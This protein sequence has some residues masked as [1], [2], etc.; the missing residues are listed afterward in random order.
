[1][2]HRIFER[3]SPNRTL[4]LPVAE[5]SFIQLPMTYEWDDA[6]WQ[7]EFG[8]LQEIGMSYLVVMGTSRTDGNKTQTTYPTSL[9]NCSMI[10]PVDVIDILLRNAS[11][12]GFKVFLGIGFN[13][14][15][16]K[17]SA[18]DPEWLYWQ[19]QR[20]NL[21]AEELYRKYH[22][23]YA[24]AFYGWYWAYEV[25]NLNFNNRK[26][27]N[28]LSE[29]LNLQLDFMS[30]SSIRLPFLLSPFI[31]SKYSCPK[32]YAD[33][34]AYVFSRTN[35]ITGDIF[36]LQ[37]SVGAGGLKVYQIPRWFRAMKKAV[38]AKP[39]LQFWANTES[40]M[41]NPFR[42]APLSRFIKQM[43][44]ESPYVDK[45]ITFSYCHYYSPNKVSRDYHK[46]YLDY[47]SAVR[48]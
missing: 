28:V 9:P 41:S 5:G 38:D 45:I 26:Q 18:N 29:A 30:A 13:N 4:P 10:S 27:Q 44:L 33:V 19:M 43:K 15:W 21:I 37:D 42:T 36:C 8:Y 17:K 40:F 24:D 3:L 7:S 20:D 16:W 35:F 6:K 47:L 14:A 12:A 22:S 2:F 11:K 32:K 1:M 23:K 46:S 25:D 31:N 48:K 34:W 39:C